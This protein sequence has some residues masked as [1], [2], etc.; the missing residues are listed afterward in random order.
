MLPDWYL[1]LSASSGSAFIPGWSNADVVAVAFIAFAIL[2]VL[3]TMIAADWPSDIAFLSLVLGGLLVVWPAMLVLTMAAIVLIMIVSF[4]HS[5]LA[6]AR[7]ARIAAEADRLVAPAIDQFARDAG[8]R[9][10]ERQRL[11]AD[12]QSEQQRR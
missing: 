9:D 2:F 1:R 3:A 6:P 5:M 7:S 10:A 11:L 4:L 8:L 12:G